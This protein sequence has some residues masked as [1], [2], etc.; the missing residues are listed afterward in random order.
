MSASG[1]EK[2]IMSSSSARENLRSK[3]EA[4][5]KRALAFIEAKDVAVANAWIV[6]REDD[7]VGSDQNKDVFFRRVH[8]L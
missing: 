8:E 3:S 4:R 5:V 7:I 6:M 2:E 1:S